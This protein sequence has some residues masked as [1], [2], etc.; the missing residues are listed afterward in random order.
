[1]APHFTER[2]NI[3]MFP[4]GVGKSDYIIVEEGYA[5]EHKSTDEISTDIRE[6]EKDKRYEMIFKKDKVEVFKKVK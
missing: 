6:L 2:E 5:F 1:M 4:D 3:Y